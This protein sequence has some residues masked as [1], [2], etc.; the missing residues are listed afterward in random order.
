MEE[1]T[2]SPPATPTEA[3][4]VAQQPLA[5]HRGTLILVFGILSIVCCLIFGIVAWVMANKDLSEMA[6]GRMDP[7]GEGMT[8]A[9]KI[10]GIIGIALQALVIVIQLILM[11][12]GAGVAMTA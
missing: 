11:I 1:Q 2:Q 3:Q 4:P 10:C 5:P 9:G 6:A 12:L 7:A 8:K